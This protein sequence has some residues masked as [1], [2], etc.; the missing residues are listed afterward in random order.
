MDITGRYKLKDDRVLF[1]QN[2]WVR[3]WVAWRQGGSVMVGDLALRE[4]IQSL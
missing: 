1:N 2:K 3:N 4:V